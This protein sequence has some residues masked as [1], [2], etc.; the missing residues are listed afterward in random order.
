MTVGEALIAGRERLRAA[1]DDGR[2]DALR[3]LEESLERNAA[4]IMAHDDD[5]VTAAAFERYAAA[6]ER[7]ARGEPAAYIVGT[8][9][10]YGRTYAVNAGVLVPRPDS[11][12]VVTL[13]LEA[14]RERERDRPAVPPRL[15]DVGTGSGILAITL[16]CEWPTAAVTA[17]DISQAALAVAE[18]NAR[19]N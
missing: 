17:L 5:V 10:F 12:H 16:A 19:A 8:V 15:C 3:L 18:G 7:R 14:L 2:F 9:G 6:L 11:E 1:G 4:W 13:A